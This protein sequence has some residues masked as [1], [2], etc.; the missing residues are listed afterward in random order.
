MI[1]SLSGTLTEASS[2]WEY[3]NGGSPRLVT[4][5]DAGGGEPGATVFVTA[6]SIHDGGEQLWEEVHLERGGVE[7]P[8]ASARRVLRRLPDGD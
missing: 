8:G 5:Q 4:R 1:T 3:G 6:R 7:V 2:A